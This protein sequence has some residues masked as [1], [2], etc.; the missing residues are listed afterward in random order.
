MSKTGSGA[1]EWQIAILHRTSRTVSSGLAIDDMLQELVSIAVEFTGCDACLVYLP[2]HETGDIVLR[3]SQL[4]HDAEIGAVRLNLGEGVA[5]WVAQQ[6]SIVA[7]SKNAFTDPRFKHFTTLVE[8]T[9]EALVSVPLIRG[10]EVIGVLNV[11]HRDPHEHTPEEIAML[12]FLGEQMGGAIAYSILAEHNQRLRKEANLVR[13]QLAERKI[14]ERA[15]G[16][17]QQ[18]F[19]LTEEEAYQR[20][21]EESRRQRRPIREVAEAVLMVEGLG[22]QHPR[23]KKSDDA[24]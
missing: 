4:P 23:A 17:L 9:Y 12:C 19:S 21:R 1:A 7:L 24:T 11:H 6:K 3:A 10:G 2:D 14:V 18:R 20:L 22:Q 13:Q 5:G 8:D 16:L 15:K